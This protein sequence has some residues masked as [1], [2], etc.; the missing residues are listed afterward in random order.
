[1]AASLFSFLNSLTLLSSC[2]TQ[3][4]DVMKAAQLIAL[5]ALALVLLSSTA[6]KPPF[7][8]AKL[9]GIDTQNRA[10]LP[11]SDSSSAHHISFLSVCQSALHDI[12]Q[13]FFP[14]CL[15]CSV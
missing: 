14:G 3:T 15:P 13:P 11:T 6:S 7:L 4:F 2:R 8:H 5:S 9:F 12:W 1:M 10:A